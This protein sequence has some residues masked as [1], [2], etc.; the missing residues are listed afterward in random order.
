MFNVARHL[1]SGVTVTNAVFYVE[2][3]FYITGGQVND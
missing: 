3:K 1:V 2:M